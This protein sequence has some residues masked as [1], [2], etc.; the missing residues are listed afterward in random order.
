MQ[1][2]LQP[3]GIWLRTEKGI[4]ESEGLVLTDGLVQGRGPPRPLFIEEHGIRYGVDV[5]EGQKTGFYLDQRE[6]RS[7]VARYV[8][9][10]RVLDLFCYTGGFGLA[11]VKLGGAR[12]VLGVDVSTPALSMARSNV[13]INGVAHCFHFE[14]AAAFDAL[15]QLR[16]AGE[17]FDTVILDPPKMTR[18]RAG[19]KK[20]LRGYYSLNRLVVDLLR[21]SGLL[22][23]CS[24]SGLISRDDFEQMLASVS[25]RANRRIQILETRSQATDH[26]TSVDCLETNY[27]KCY[28]CR[29]E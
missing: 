5:V 19:L 29:V 27:L 14:H 2:K 20:A 1:E 8:G 3:A 24:C 25:L 26:P 16:A 15:E 12:S 21:P 23:T 7:A 6:N 10:H 28:I 13:E 18:H 4:R 22:V 9:G 11:A 17:L